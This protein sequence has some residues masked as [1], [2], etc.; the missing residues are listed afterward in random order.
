MNWAQIK[1]K[2]RY[3]DQNE[4]AELLNIPIRT[5]YSVIRRESGTTEEK[6]KSTLTAIIV[7]REQVHNSVKNILT[8][9]NTKDEELIKENS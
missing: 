6:I 2:I 4:V 9:K 5:V 3:G 8:P 1:Q 7:N